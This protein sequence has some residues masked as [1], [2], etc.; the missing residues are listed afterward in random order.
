M[1]LHYFLTVLEIFSTSNVGSCIVCT[2]RVPPHVSHRH[3]LT[4]C[5]LPPYTL[6]CKPLFSTFLILNIYISYLSNAN[7][8]R[9]STFNFLLLLTHSFVC[10]LSLTSSLRSSA[11]SYSI[12]HEEDGSLYHFAKCSLIISLNFPFKPSYLTRDIIT[13]LTST[14]Q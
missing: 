10:F 14:I 7:R 1:T 6:S 12:C 13:T 4:R 8:L 9:L 3:A 5:S 11:G 2:V